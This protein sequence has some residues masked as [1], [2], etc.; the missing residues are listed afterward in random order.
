MRP[1]GTAKKRKN[2]Y[3]RIISRLQFRVEEPGVQVGDPKHFLSQIHSLVAILENGGW[4][5]SK[6]VFFSYGN[7]R[8]LFKIDKNW[9]IFISPPAAPNIKR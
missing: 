7:P 9:Y 3:P 2:L 4:Q 8:D 1:K 6:L 5:F